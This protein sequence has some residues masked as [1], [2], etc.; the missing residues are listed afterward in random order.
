LN[1]QEW[2]EPSCIS[3]GDLVYPNGSSLKTIKFEFLL[4]RGR[5]KGDAIVVSMSLRARLYAD[6]SLIWNNPSAVCKYL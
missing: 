3:K 4:R 6:I 5:E 1:P 2:P